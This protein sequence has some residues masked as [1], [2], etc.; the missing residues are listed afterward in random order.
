MLIIYT[1]SLKI[2]YSFLIVFWFSV[3]ALMFAFYIFQVI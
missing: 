3:L 1:A 2:L